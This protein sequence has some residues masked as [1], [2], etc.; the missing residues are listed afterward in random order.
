MKIFFTPQYTEVK[1]KAK[2]CAQ[3]AS[4]PTQGGTYDAISEK[5][6]T[7]ELPSKKVNF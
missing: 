5:L 1:K 7:S 2:S 6:K 3:P 4:Y